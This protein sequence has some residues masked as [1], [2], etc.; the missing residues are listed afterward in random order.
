MQ[1]RMVVTGGNGFLGRHI[2]RIGAESGAA[3]TSIGRSGR[4]PGVTDWEKQ[5]IEWVAADV[6][7][8]G[9]WE[10]PLA[11]CRVVVHCIATLEQDSA[12]G[13]TH[14]RLI[15]ESARVVGQAA[16]GADVSRFVYISAASAPP[17][18]P[19]SYLQ[20]KRAAEEFLATLPFALIVLRPSAIYGAERPESLRTRRIMELI[21]RFPLADRHMRASRPLPVEAVARA[22]VHTALGP[23]QPALLTVDDIEE[24]SRTRP[25]TST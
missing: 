16:A 24:I 23:A 8:P 10:G 19:A 22:A 20:S 5:H 3:V 2:C 4:P 11:G 21:A 17:G 1:V 7:Q 15:L 12:K 9:T 13:V 6:F 25:S 14:Q 18:T